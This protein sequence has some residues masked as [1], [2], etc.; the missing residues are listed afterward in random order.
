MKT[1]LKRIGSLLL[2]STIILAI[3]CSDDDPTFNSL[4]ELSPEAKAF[5]GMRNGSNQALS[6]NR[7]ANPATASI[8]KS[9]QGAYNSYASVSG[10]D[11]VSENSDTTIVEPYPL[12]GWESCATITETSNPDGS[13]TTTTDYGDGCEEGDE[14]Y[15]YFMHGKTSYT[16]K[17][18]QSQSGSIFKYS[19]LTKYLSENYGGKYYYENDTTEWLSNGHSTYSGESLYDSVDQSFSGSYSYSDTSEYTYDDV[20]YI[21]KSIGQSMYDQHKSVIEASNYEYSYGSDY[22]KSEVLTPLVMDYSCM[23]WTMG[24]MDGV[25]GG[26]IMPYWSTYV[27]GRERVQFKQGDAVGSFEID[28]GNGE[29]DNIIVIYE[30]GKV[31]SID[32]SRDY[33]LLTN[34]G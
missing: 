16:Y 14:Y 33:G 27:S 12:P 24:G 15:S 29:C 11:G 4:E 13:T 32:L 26:S 7:N 19:Y 5:L 30:N 20:T 10:A 28:Y 31:F 22:Y 21:Y 6:A 8:N 34:G 1:P 9:F 3:G 2:I 23:S 25:N 18:V 17:Y